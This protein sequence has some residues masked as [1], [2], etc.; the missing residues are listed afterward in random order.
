MLTETV[1]RRLEQLGELSRQ[2]KR[3]NG[4]FRLME[5]PLL[6]DEAYARIYANNGATTQGVDHTTLDGFSIEQAGCTD[7]TP[8]KWTVPVSPHPSSLRA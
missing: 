2:G 7:C 3:V 4:L 5:C 8:E 6:W 1:L